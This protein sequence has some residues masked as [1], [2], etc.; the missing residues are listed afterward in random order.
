VHL[1]AADF[2]C[3][4]QNT[5]A[6]GVAGKIAFCYRFLSFFLGDPMLLLL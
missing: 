5:L 1:S 4:W 3:E 6:G 2:G